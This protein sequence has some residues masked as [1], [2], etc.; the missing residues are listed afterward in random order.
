MHRDHTEHRNTWGSCFAPR[1]N[2]RARLFEGYIS[3]QHLSFFNLKPCDHLSSP[4]ATLFSF[5]VGAPI[6][7]S[8]SEPTLVKN[9]RTLMDVTSPTGKGG[10]SQLGPRS[11][12]R[13]SSSTDIKATEGTSCSR[14]L[15]LPPKR[16]R[17]TPCERNTAFIDPDFQPLT[18][19]ARLPTGPYA[20]ST[21]SHTRTRL[22]VRCGLTTS[23][24]MEEDGLAMGSRSPEPLK[25]EAFFS[26]RQTTT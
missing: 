19:S 5:A 22:A 8:E 1:I 17:L 26:T 23:W 12:P 18:M 20:G 14:A 15:S 4:W 11:S 16:R 7:A 2:Y 3:P 13:G 21:I 25:W 6:P 9:V 24:G 10:R